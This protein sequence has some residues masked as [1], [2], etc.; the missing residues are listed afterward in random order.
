MSETITSA[1]GNEINKV[2]ACINECRRGGDSENPSIRFTN[3]KGRGLDVE[4]SETPLLKV[5]AD[6]VVAEEFDIN[7]ETIASILEQR[8]DGR[9][10]GNHRVASVTIHEAHGVVVDAHVV[11]DTK[12][13]DTRE[14]LESD[15]VSAA[16]A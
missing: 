8:L 1:A 16:N 6:R 3:I 9:K 4:V 12:S 10:V 7:T 11:A 2:E 15:I 13:D 14:E 5:K